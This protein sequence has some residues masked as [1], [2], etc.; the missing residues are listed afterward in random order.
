[1]HAIHRCRQHAS[2]RLHTL[3]HVCA[4]RKA[5][6]AAAAVEPAAPAG[7]R[8]ALL[9]LRQDLRVND[10]AALCEAAKWAA[11]HAGR[12]TFLYVH[13]PAED[14]DEVGSSSGRCG[15][16]VGARMDVQGWEKWGMGG[17]V[18]SGCSCVQHHRA[19]CSPG[20]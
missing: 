5:K 9:W 2:S 12:V 4:G 1:M 16:G 17:G 6:D 15:V 18:C 11:R 3:S 20:A 7:A 10:N 19:V 13:S 8:N 14:G